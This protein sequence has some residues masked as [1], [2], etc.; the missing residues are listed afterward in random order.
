LELALADLAQIEK[1]LEKLKKGGS[2]MSMHMIAARRMFSAKD[3]QC[4][5]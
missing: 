2:G 1:R 4:Q 5:G 3:V